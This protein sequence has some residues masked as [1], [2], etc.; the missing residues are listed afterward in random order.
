MRFQF[1]RNKGLALAVQLWEEF[2]MK[3]ISITCFMLLSSIAGGADAEVLDE[4]TDLDLAGVIKAINFGETADHVIGGVTFRAAPANSAVDGVKN[5]AQ[6]MVRVG[7]HR[8]TLPD[9]GSSAED[10]A[11]EQILGTSIFGCRSGTD[12]DIDIPVANGFYR[13]Q[14]ILYNGWQSVT[15]AKRNVNHLIEETVAARNYQD[16]VAQGNTPN[17]GCVATYVFEVKDGQIDITLPGVV[18]NA[19]LSGL[20][21]SKLT[22]AP[23]KKRPRTQAGRNLGRA[24]SVDLGRAGTGAAVRGAKARPDKAVD[25]CPGG[26]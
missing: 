22:T 5:V 17:A 4:P 12:I 11:L 9:V 13:A 15:G 25:V 18:P 2:A 14:L 21:V 8:Q 19:H 3:K 1:N 7:Q 20:V 10:D 6:G 16:Y 24:D 23:G 26:R